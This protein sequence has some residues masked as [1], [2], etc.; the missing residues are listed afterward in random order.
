MVAENE[1]AL[2]MP[3]GMEIDKLLR[4]LIA[5]TILMSA[6]MAESIRG[7]LQAI[8]TALPQI[9]SNFIGL[10][11]ETTILLIVG[12]FDLLGMVQN[13][14]SDSDWLSSGVSATGYLFA[15]LFFWLC[16]F[17]LSRYSARLERRT[18]PP[19]RNI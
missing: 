5:L 17:S 6:Y 8:P 15:A 2:F 9:T 10:F 7:A 18:G 11:K 4:A 3:K 14:A 19:K 1:F 12:L 13:A 16:C